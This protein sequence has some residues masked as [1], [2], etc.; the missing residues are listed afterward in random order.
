MFKISKFQVYINY[1]IITIVVIP[2]SYNAWNDNK[3]FLFYFFLVAGILSLI[4][5]FIALINIRKQDNF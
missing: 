5:N 4:V 3:M 1:F 2:I